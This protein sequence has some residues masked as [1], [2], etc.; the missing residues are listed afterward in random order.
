MHAVKE[1]WTLFF[2][3][4]CL[5]PKSLSVADD[6]GFKVIC[7]LHH[8]LFFAQENSAVLEQKINS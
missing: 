5:L 8:L 7:L 6:L 3:L 4:F 2:S 1:E